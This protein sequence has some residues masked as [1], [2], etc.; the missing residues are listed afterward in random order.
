MTAKST[1]GVRIDMVTGTSGD[2]LTPTAVTKAKPAV[3]SVTSATGINPNDILKFASNSTGMTELDGLPWIAGTVA[4]STI[5]LPGS[6]LTGDSDVFAAGDPI[7][8][9]QSTEMTRLCWSGM[10][11]NPDTP[12][13]VSV[14]TYC[15]PTATIPGST[16]SAGT[17]DFTGYV[18]IEEPDYPAMLVAYENGTEHIF[19]VTIPNNGTLVFSGVISSLNLDIPINGATAYNGQIALSSR[20]RHLF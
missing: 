13:T 8:V 1:R 6:D 11:F 18:D 7:L 17:L 3:L 2:S 4:G 16:A 9:Y 10:T 20:P 14:G 15:D 19:R 12:E 5:P